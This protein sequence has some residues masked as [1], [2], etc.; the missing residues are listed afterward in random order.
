MPAPQFLIICCWVAFLAAWAL[1]ARGQKETIERKRLA[2]KLAYWPLLVVG[3]GLIFNGFSHRRT[4]GRLS[5][6]LLE[7]Q[8]M[9]GWSGL[10]IAL[11]GL[12]VAIWARRA[13]GRNWSA[14]VVLK[15]EHEL[16]A[17]GPYAFVRHPIYTGLELLFLGSAIAL[18]T[19]AG[20]LGFLLTLCSCWIKLRQE[21]RLMLRAFGEEY[22]A[23]A[24]RTK[25]LIPFIW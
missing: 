12:S 11:L 7:P 13:L 21:E 18:G 22:A 8:P 5:E 1:M 14:S 25:R 23:Y 24:R 16:V 4:L 17:T 10:A 2:S 15:K 20:F 6:P 19:R 9:A 3:A